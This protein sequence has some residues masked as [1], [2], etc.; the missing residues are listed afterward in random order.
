M[1]LIKKIVLLVFF[2]TLIFSCKSKLKVFDFKNKDKK[3][4]EHYLKMYNSIKE[5]KDTLHLFKNIF[6][7]KIN[8]EEFHIGKIKNGMKYGKWY[9]YEREDNSTKCYSVEKINKRT[10]ETEIIWISGF[11]NETFF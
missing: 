10:Q 4:S 2:L 11:V 1:A 3:T 9:L 6:S 5:K 8:P 7:I